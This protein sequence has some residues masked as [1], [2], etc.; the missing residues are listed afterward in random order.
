[1][2]ALL[3]W[4]ALHDVSPGEVWGE[5][6]RAHPGWL[7]A[8]VVAATLS[9]PL[10]T[11]RWRYLLRDQGAVLPM[12][13]LW[14]ATAIGFMA[15]NLLP[16]RAGEFARAY[17]VRSLTG[18]RFTTAF[19]SVAVER[20]FDGL[21][22]VGLLVVG[23]VAGGFTTATTIQGVQL[24]HIALGGAAL[25]GSVFVAAVAVVWQ[26]AVTRRLAHAAL[27]RVL[28]TRWADR[29]LALVDGVLD[30]LSALRAPGRLGAVLVWSL[31]LWLTNAASFWL[32]FVA[33]GLSL[34]WG[35]AL[36]LQGILAFGVAIPST[37][38]FFGVFEGVT[39]ASLALYGVAGTSAVSLAIGYH[40]AGFIPITVLGLWS[41]WK[42]G[43]HLRDL[44][45]DER[46]GRDD[47]MTG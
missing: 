41:L 36:V 38:G 44:K 6:R 11:I 30:G 13:A 19:A 29:V 28:P 46:D 34:P 3:L 47:G 24:S 20:V 18:V 32:A 21:F 1:V 40:I 25:F 5:I 23:F 35:A 17:A 26:P 4:W 27:H 43:L 39:R 33:F 12:G 9:F 15:N 14:H 10:R 2:S 22:L 7:F 42:A 16:A 31:V 45:R 8:A 37:P